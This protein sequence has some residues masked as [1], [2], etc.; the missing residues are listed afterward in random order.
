MSESNSDAQQLSAIFLRI[1][2]Q[3]NSISTPEWLQFDLTFQQ[4][5]VLYIIKQYGPLTMSDLHEKLQVSMPTITGIVNRLIERRDGKPLLAR[6]T[7]PQDR[8]EVR[9]RLTDEGQEVINKV[10]IVQQELLEAIF[11]QFSLDELEATRIVLERLGEV[12]EYT[13]SNKR[14]GNSDDPENL[15]PEK[16]KRRKRQTLS[17]REAVK[18][19]LTVDANVTMSPLRRYENYSTRPILT[20]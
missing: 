14:N 17:V 15:S 1:I 6:E 18:E 5:K 20:S 3:L 16:S 2:Q 12:A 11:S 10:G 13:R 8:R 19:A 9:A 7:S 4:M